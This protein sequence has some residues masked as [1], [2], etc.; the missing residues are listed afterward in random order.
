[1]EKAPKEDMDKAKVALFDYDEGADLAVVDRS[2]LEQAASCPWMA[3]AIAD[4]RCATV[5][6][7]AEAGEEGHKAFSQTLHSWIDSRGAMEKSDLR[8]D[9]EFAVRNARPDLQPEAIRSI[10]GSIW[11][12]S[13]LIYS[14]HP[15]NILAFDGGEDINKSGQLAYDIPDMGVRFT[16]ELDLL[17]QGD[18]P[19][20]GEE[21]DYKTGWKDW[22][23]EAIRD[24]LQFQCHAVLALEKYPQWKALR[25]RVFETRSRNLTYGVYFP[26]ERI[27]DWKMRIRSA[28]SAWKFAQQENPPTWPVLEKCT[29]CP[30]ACLCPVADEAIADLAED[31]VRFVRS[32]VAVEARASAMSKMAAAW[33]DEHKQDIRAGD[34]YFGRQKPKTDRKA[35]ATIYSIKEKSNGDGN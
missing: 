27:H 34:V 5:G 12:W 30:A 10:Q 24:S 9:V 13:H 23:T 7:L 25:V 26:R 28:V 8:Q 4:K 29:L 21:V 2:T 17:Y 1:M 31:P 19:D 15:S 3:K 32:L 11:S 35:N 18:C 14:I 20:V 22:T 16:S 6:I 33:I